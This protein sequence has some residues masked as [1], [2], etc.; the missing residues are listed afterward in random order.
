MKK[1]IFIFTALFL[2]YL[3]SNAQNI[4][5]FELEINGFYGLSG[6]KGSVVDGSITPGLGYQLSI[7]GKYFFTS[8]F[9]IGIGAGYASYNSMVELKNYVSNT[10]AI[11]D[12]SENFE[13]RVTASGIKE[14]IELRTF[15]IPVFLSCKLPLSDKLG[16]VANAGVKASI[17]IT[18]TYQCTAGALE[19]KGYYSSNNVEYSNMPNHGFESIDKISFSGQLS[20]E[21]A[22]SLFGNIGISIPLGKISLNLSVL[23]SYG[24]NAAIKPFGNLLIDYPGKYNSISSLSEQV[25]VIGGSLKFGVSF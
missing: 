9:G 10:S 12:E 22:Y 8:N 1:Y 19:T 20:S 18:A 16:L 5:K 7:D 14:N 2:I 17:P 15:E 25:S 23:G 4:K 21:M 11:D 6:L 13:Y 3:V 24:L